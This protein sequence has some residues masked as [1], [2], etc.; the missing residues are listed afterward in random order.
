MGSTINEHDHVA[1]RTAASVLR[2][3]SMHDVHAPGLGS[4]R[5]V[6]APGR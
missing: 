2:P 3:E 1:I 5:L 6:G 4:S